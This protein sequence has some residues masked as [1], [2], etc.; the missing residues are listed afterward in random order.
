MVHAQPA[1][2]QGR[3]ADQQQPCANLA[4]HVGDA[5]AAVVHR[6]Q[7]G[8]AAGMSRQIGVPPGLGRALHAHP[9]AVVD[10]AG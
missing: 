6:A 3:Q 1:D 9:V 4:E 5:L 2:Q 8:V 7:F 10:T